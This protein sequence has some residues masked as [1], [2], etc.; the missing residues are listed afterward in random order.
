[1]HWQHED[2]LVIKQA[3][4]LHPV[5][6][7]VKGKMEW[8]ERERESELD[9]E[10]DGG[11]D[12]DVALLKGKRKG[13]KAFKWAEVDLVYSILLLSLSL[14]LTDNHVTVT[15]Q[16]MSSIK[17]FSCLNKVT[18][19]ATTPGL[20]DIFFIAGT[21]EKTQPHPQHSHMSPTEERG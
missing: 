10:R 5:R 14:P 6:P 11:A 4:Y 8:S 16:M 13:W 15:N 17:S 18:P 7:P 12:G 19:P 3:S 2:R 1:M 9:W 20:H 21:T